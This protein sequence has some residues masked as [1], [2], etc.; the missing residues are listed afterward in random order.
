MKTLTGIFFLLFLMTACGKDEVEVI[1]DPVNELS[2][3]YRIIHSDDQKTY[4]VSSPTIVYRSSSW[5][6]HEGKVKLNKTVGFRFDLENSE[7]FGAS[8]EVN[9]SEDKDQLVLHD[10][11][12]EYWKRGWDYISTDTEIQNLWNGEENPVLIYINGCPMLEPSE[13]H[14]LKA[15]KALVNGKEKTYVKFSFSGEAYSWYDPEKGSKGYAVKNGV[16]EGYID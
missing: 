11:E 8:I 13:F 15:Q 7:K 14:L 12:L 10:E 3:E 1:A 4:K 6:N 5:H 2:F 9:G 16:F